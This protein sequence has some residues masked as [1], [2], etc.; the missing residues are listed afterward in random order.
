MNPEAEYS[1]NFTEQG[2]SFCLCLHYNGS[3]S[4]LFANGVKIYKFKAKNFELN[5]YPM[6]LGNISK[7][8]A[9]NNL[10][11]TEPK[12]Y[13]YNFSVDCE[14]INTDDIPDIYKYFNEN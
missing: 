3:N 11:Q 12:R 10:N 5:T 6:C 8:F 9:V 2:K 1:I 14:S 13:V 7:D 4:Y